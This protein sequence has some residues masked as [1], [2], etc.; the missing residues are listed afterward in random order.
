[1]FLHNDFEPITEVL[2]GAD[3][4]VTR[5]FVCPQPSARLIILQEAYA[6]EDCERSIAKLLGHFASDGGCLTV[7]VEGDDCVVDLDYARSCGATIAERIA[8]GTK[9]SAGVLEALLDGSSGL[10]V[11]GVDSHV[12]TKR[13]HEAQANC[14]KYG[15]ALI[16]A[17]A[18]IKAWLRGARHCA[19]F[20]ADED[21]L[22]EWAYP[23]P[24]DNRALKE[25]VMFLVNASDT[26][27]LSQFP[28]VV[29]MAD[30]CTREGRLVREDAEFEH[31]RLIGDILSAFRRLERAA[32]DGDSLDWVTLQSLFAFCATRH[33]EWSAV[34]RCVA[35]KGLAQ[36]ILDCLR[37]VERDLV[38]GAVKRRGG[39]SLLL[40]KYEDIL[41]LAVV[42]GI[43]LCRYNRLRDY[44][45]YLRSVVAITPTELDRDLEALT[46]R[47]LD[48]RF[49][50]NATWAMIARLTRWLYFLDAA[51]SMTLS[52]QMER[53]CDDF[54]G[55]WEA[56]LAELEELCAA[57]PG[58]EHGPPIPSL[59]SDAVTALESA[60]DF[61][62]CSGD[63]ARHMVETALQHMTK[64]SVERAVLVCGGYHTAAI[65]DLLQYR[66]GDVGWSVILPNVGKALGS[67]A[68]S[69]FDTEAAGG[70][71][72]DR[73]R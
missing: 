37:C 9:V 65:T 27:V 45:D 7:F 22:L 57:L 43:D 64:R 59:K 51:A 2:L 61:W 1:M 71:E 29:A 67:G 47:L 48:Q 34:D 12:L 21:A 42:H 58:L 50:G 69:V 13:H 20:T 11:Q 44:L 72:T 30:A 24:G 60:M 25:R 38:E 39:L 49:E 46:G 73:L 68:S 18:P 19:G 28:M 70:P 26:E 41:Q 66:Y 14:L 54:D 3:G 40:A 16:T 5:V 35:E 55:T 17:L 8:R 15:D 33:P 56:V 36:V 6:Y 32:Q 52:P 53:L 23:P 31:K 10:T 4:A 62:Q 63:R